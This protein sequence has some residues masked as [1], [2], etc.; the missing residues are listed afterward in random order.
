M[1][2]TSEYITAYV[3]AKDQGPRGFPGPP[4]PISGGVYPSAGVAVSTGV[5][6]ATS[7]TTSGSGTVLALTAG[8]TFTGTVT[9]G[10]ST[11]IPNGGT[12]GQAAGPLLNFDDTNNYLEITGCSVGLNTTTPQNL[13]HLYRGTGDGFDLRIGYTTGYNL[14]LGYYVGSEY[15]IIQAYSSDESHYDDIAI[16]PLGGNVGFGTVAPNAK[17]ESLATTEQLRLSYDATHYTSFT[18]ASGGGLTVQPLIDTNINFSLTGTSKVGIDNAAPIHTLDVVGT[19]GVSGDATHYASTETESFVSGFG[20]T[21]WQITHGGRA[22]VG[23]LV[24]RGGM[25]IYELIINRMHYQNGGLIIGPGAGTVATV[26]D[27]TVGAEVV[28]FADPYGASVVPLGAHSIVMCQRVDIN[29]TDVVKKYVREVD[30]I[31]GINVTFKATAGWNPAVDD[32]GVVMAGDEIV[33]IGDTTTASLQN[34]IYMTATDTNNPYLAVFTSVDSYSDWLANARCKLM[35]GNLAK[36]AS[37]S[38]GDLTLPA[39][40]GYGFFSDNCYLSGT[41]VAS[42]GLIGGFTIESDKMSTTL[43]TGYI[44][45]IDEDGVFSWAYMN[46]YCYSQQSTP[47]TLTAPVYYVVAL[48]HDSESTLNL[49]AAG[50]PG[51]GQSTSMIIIHAKG[52]GLGAGKY[53]ISGNGYYV[54]KGGVQASSFDLDEGK[55]VLVVWDPRQG[56]QWYAIG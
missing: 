1:P 38:Y 18:V 39:S 37:A 31:V 21:G 55:A 42:A 23:Q 43:G 17:T 45:Y 4:G 52:T 34:S 27:D 48:D 29:R 14:K 46:S 54:N 20:G 5:A 28:T 33:V 36:I 11:V 56:G 53:L 51:S 35:I 49:P 26:T 16:N 19:F 7:Y 13:L 25:W 47:V 50:L 6:W 24:C 30:S 9:L 12:I 32:V 44:S 40:P 10:A 22:E 3:K 2:T 41:I 8:P 15:G